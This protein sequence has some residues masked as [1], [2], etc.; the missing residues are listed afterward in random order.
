[1]KVFPALRPFTASGIEFHTWGVR[2]H[3]A[4]LPAKFSPIGEIAQ[5]VAIAACE[6]TYIYIRV[7]N[8]WIINILE[9]PNSRLVDTLIFQHLFLTVYFIIQNSNFLLLY[10]PFPWIFLLSLYLLSPSAL[11][12]FYYTLIFYFPGWV[13]F[14]TSLLLL[15]TCQSLIYICH[16]L[17][18]HFPSS[19]ACFSYLSFIL[20][21]P[22]LHYKFVPA[23][24]HP[25]C[26]HAGIFWSAYCF[27]V[28]KIQLT[29]LPHWACLSC[30]SCLWPVTT[31]H[32]LCQL[33]CPFKPPI[34]VV[35]LI[36]AKRD[37]CRRTRARTHTFAYINWERGKC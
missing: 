2:R 9:L 34:I 1:M 32:R 24:S 8:Q 33:T 11:S 37:R 14:F 21:I 6:H 27:Q 17:I 18:F 25:I 22:L 19:A 20:H 7:C 13:H 23:P 28:I 12:N 3:L 30:V 36:I 10:F 5:A 29:S 16:P 4:T 26:G 35:R 31:A 15:S